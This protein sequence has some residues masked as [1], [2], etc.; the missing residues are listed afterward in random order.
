MALTFSITG[1]ADAAKFSIGATSGVL[2]FKAAPDFEVPG[3]A[4]QDN[5][6]IVEVGV[7]DGTSTTKQ[8]ISVT[9]TDVA[10]SNLP[11]Q[12]TSPAAK[13]VSE[14]STEVM[15]V[16]ATDPD[17]GGTTPPPVTGWP[18]ASTTGAKGTLTASGN[19]TTTGNNQIIKDK[20]CSGTIRIVG[21]HSG[22]KIQN[23]SAQL[24]AMV[25]GNG[26]ITA[27]ANCIIEDCTIR[28]T[29]GGQQTG[30]QFGTAGGTVQRCDVSGVENGINIEAVNGGTIRDN[31]VHN[32]ASPG[33]PD[34]H[35]DCIPMQGNQS[36]ILVE[37]NNLVHP[38]GLNACVFLKTDWGPVTNITVNNNRMIGGTMTV[39]ADNNPG[40]GMTGIKFTNNRMDGWY[41]GPANVAN[42]TPV[43]TGNVKDS[44]GSPISSY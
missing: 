38:N 21:N 1:G 7:S 34:P 4:N 35:Y 27:G 12:I 33:N 19:I 29:G 43:W 11:P 25:D 2:A 24:I 5:V 9:V 15:T 6:Y 13:T 31:Y 8:T 40:K 16:T 18:D 14:N 26:N 41:Y 42:C 44:D 17:G 39:Y 32:L 28:G 30:I 3:D 23:C 22:V 36:N 20:N 37:H 10:D